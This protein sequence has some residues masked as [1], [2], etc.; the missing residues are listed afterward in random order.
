MKLGK[1]T[2]AFLA[3]A[4]SILSVGALAGTN[5]QTDSFDVY[6]ANVD[7]DNQ[8]DLIFIARERFVLISGE[9][10]VPL[11][12]KDSEDFVLIQQADGTYTYS[13]DFSYSVNSSDKVTLSLLSADFNNDGRND[14]VISQDN[15]LVY[16][17]GGSGSGP[18]SVESVSELAGIPVTPDYSFTQ[19]TAEGGKQGFLVT[20]SVN[21]AT[22]LID[23]YGN[24]LNATRNYRPT[25]I[26]G[27][28]KGRF[29]V[30][31]GGGANY[32]LPVSLPDGPGGYKP[33]I[34]FRYDSQGGNG[35]LGK[36]WSVTG[37]EAIT[38]CSGDKPNLKAP[39]MVKEDTFCINGQT[40]VLVWGVHGENNAQYRTSKDSGTL[41]VARSI[42]SSFGGATYF[43]VYLEDGTTK[44]FG[45]TTNSRILSSETGKVKTW[46]LTTSSQ[47]GGANYEVSYSVNRSAGEFHISSVS[48]GVNKIEY[49]YEERPDRASGWSQGSRFAQTK[50]L[51]SLSVKS[52]NE[53]VR[54]Y[55]VFYGYTDELK[56]S[57]V[58]GIQL[59][60]KTKCLAPAKFQ[61]NGVSASSW[62]LSARKSDFLNNRRDSLIVSDL[63]GDSKAD[64]TIVGKSIDNSGARVVTY[65]GTTNGY[66]GN[67]VDPV[68]N[69]MSA[70]T[71]HVI[72]INGDGHNDLCQFSSSYDIRCTIFF[73]DLVDEDTPTIN[74]RSIYITGMGGGTAHFGDV[75][76]DGLP[77][78]IKADGNNVEV[79]KFSTSSST[80]AASKTARIDEKHDSIATGD[81]NGDGLTDVLYN[82]GK[83]AFSLKYSKGT[84]G[85]GLT[86]PVSISAAN[87]GA[88]TG[89]STAFKQFMLTDMNGDGLSDIVFLPY[90]YDWTIGGNQNE[91]LGSLRVM[92]SNGDGFEDAVLVANECELKYEKSPN[93]LSVFDV[94]GDGRSD[95]V[96][97][98]ARMM[99][100]PGTG[101][102]NYDNLKF[103]VYFTNASG[104]SSS[105]TL[106]DI[107]INTD[108]IRRP[109]E[110]PNPL[111]LSVGDVDGNGT[112]DLV[113]YTTFDDVEAWTFLRNQTTYHNITGIEDSYENSIDI[114]YKPMSD[115]LVYHRID[116]SHEMALQNKKRVYSPGKVLVHKTETDS[117]DRLERNEVYYRYAGAFSDNTHGYLGHS[118]FLTISDRGSH[119]AQLNWEEYGL[120]SATYKRQ[121]FPYVGM[122]EQVHKRNFAGLSASDLYSS[123]HF[124]GELEP[125]AYVAHDGQ[126]TQLYAS[127]NETH[128]EIPEDSLVQLRSGAQ[129]GAGPTSVFNEWKNYSFADGKINKP[130]LYKTSQSL[131]DFNDSNLIRNKTVTTNLYEKVDDCFA[132]Q[133]GT[134]TTSGLYTYVLQVKTTSSN[135]VLNSGCGWPRSFRA[136][137]VETTTTAMNSDWTTELAGLSLDTSKT[138]VTTNVYSADGQIL[139]TGHDNG[140]SNDLYTLFEYENANVVKSTQRPREEADQANWEDRTSILEYHQNTSWVSKVSNPEG[141]VTQTT[142][143]TPYGNPIR[144]IQGATAAQELVF[145]NS[146]D[147]LERISY[148]VSPTGQSTTITRGYCSDGGALVGC[149]DPTKYHTYIKTVVSGAPDQYQFFNKVGLLTKTAI[150]HFDGV[151]YQTV[152]FQYDQYGRLEKES[153]PQLEPLGNESTGTEWTRYYY[154]LNDR[155][156]RKTTPAGG[157][158]TISFETIANV[159]NTQ[160]QV[161]KIGV[162][163]FTG[164]RRIINTKVTNDVSR[165]TI[166]L[167]SSN[168]KLMSVTAPNGSETHFVYDVSGNIVLEKYSKADHSDYLEQ[169]EKK[170]AGFHAIERKFDFHENLVKEIDPSKGE[171]QY[172][173]N[174]FG[175]AIEFITPNVASGNF[176][177]STTLKYDKLGRVTARHSPE[178][179]VCWYFDETS[180]GK[181]LG[182]L[183]E[184][185]QYDSAADCGVASAKPE[186]FTYSS[187]YS[188]NDQGLPSATDEKFVNFKGLTKTYSTTN[189]YDGFGRLSKVFYPGGDLDVRLNYNDEGYLSSLVNDRSPSEYYE[190]LLA[191]NELGETSKLKLGNQIEISRFHE[192][193]RTSKLISK[194]STMENLRLEYAYD[195]A[196]NLTRIEDGVAR[197]KSNE[198]INQ[199][200]RITNLYYQDAAARQLTDVIDKFRASSGYTWVYNSEKYQYDLNGNI[201]TRTGAGTYHYD[202]ENNPHQVSSITGLNLTY[203]YDDNGNVTS[204][205]LR[206]LEYTSFDKPRSITQQGMTTEYKYGPNLERLYR[207]DVKNGVVKE[208][209]NIAGGMLELT[210]EGQKTERRHYVG[211]N[212]T[213]VHKV[214]AN[215][216]IIE[217]KLFNVKDHLGSVV[218]QSNGQGYVL[219]RYRYNP[220]GEQETIY[221][222]VDLGTITL[223][224]EINWSGYV[225]KKGFTGHDH[226]YEMDLIH[227][228]GRVYDHTTGRFLQGDIVV[229]L[230]GFSNAYNRYAYVLNN[231]LSYTDPT[232]YEYECAE[233]GCSLGYA[234]RSEISDKQAA[235]DDQWSEMKKNSIGTNY[236]PYGQIKDPSLYEP[237]VN[238]GR[239]VY[240]ADAA[241][242]TGLPGKI[243]DDPYV[244]QNV[245][246]YLATPEGKAAQVAGTAANFAGLPKAGKTVFK[247]L[248][249]AI[250]NF[251]GGKGKRGKKGKNDVDDTCDVASFVTG[252]NVW[253]EDGLEDIEDIEVGDLVV[254]KSFD[255][256]HVSSKSVSQLFSSYH[257]N[258]VIE[259]IVQNE[260]GEKDVITTTSEH[261]FWV[262]GE[263]WVD[264]AE[265]TL[266]DVLTAQNGESIAI[267][268]IEWLDTGAQTYNFTV[269]DYHTYAVGEFG[270]WVHNCPDEPSRTAA[271]GE[272]F[273]KTTK[274]AT[275]AAKELGYRK[276]NLRT[277]GEA[278]YFNKKDKLYMSRDVGSG[279]GNGAHNGGV[280][281]LAKTAEGLGKKETRMGTYDADLVW[282][283]D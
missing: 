125:I 264:A 223:P 177:S 18:S 75:T 253:I 170:G 42:S 175:E 69:G 282:I 25:T 35:L 76:G 196:G 91:T 236:D 154:D 248:G 238:G 73:S 259:L 163:Y 166:E 243:T 70:G 9:I 233:R 280:W 208:T 149:N 71:S 139:E 181:S 271:K 195:F 126:T 106:K 165:E 44:T 201:L 104:M 185:R 136:Q 130:Y 112:Q 225:D 2:S 186:G 23:R 123:V 34:S 184:V 107:A 46:A 103:D 277:H 242:P 3:F 48:Y 270:V 204:D 101:Y 161:R 17:N 118:V 84:K 216:G 268:S 241:L 150:L 171:S 191:M 121:D 155:M 224:V 93:S 137:K 51:K 39:V 215:Q 119:N 89:M 56:H 43:D 151:N 144:V 81:F 63:S 55:T 72:D 167:Y 267:Q 183:T 257:E 49:N 109:D 74:R 24:P 190:V 234:D 187:G 146:Y 142:S 244:K 272:I 260:N 143:Y 239:I 198:Y 217:E 60:L 194:Y 12:V 229:Q 256:S 117:A 37:S 134:I 54:N 113:A 273:Y 11:I 87:Y 45:A 1:F 65:R 176:E 127:S 135:F 276:T 92:F 15:Q 30:T 58:N 6:E 97:I 36:G 111:S 19:Y 249:Q 8:K 230:S 212:T 95:L 124:E 168:D 152:Y 85:G 172:K 263:G 47:P 274:E 77:D 164:Y 178:G 207:K 99:V 64:F 174:P 203:Q 197:D 140:K 255:T 14:L 41:V 279:D 59:C 169:P 78:L 148:S 145:E 218:L 199:T 86:E 50:R 52:N 240:L 13:N 200:H 252:T 20:Y 159:P 5:L 202:E 245:E 21:G 179:S 10:S 79:Y 100:A 16:L 141:H 231:P 88:P 67:K 82:A 250:G 188:Y 40:L 160:V 83:L 180:A 122:T 147:E 262:V 210:K 246:A 114:E 265:L 158:T 251:F 237:D 173:Y 283:A 232:G 80:N 120:I 38:R 53:L 138:V 32:S 258:D 275:E 108:L 27:N 102:L 214:Q 206:T 90:Y 66:F 132:R 281:K 128:V 222:A 182:M 57:Y 209:W 96:C 254:A 266:L 189:Q 94:N 61:W 26:V 29:T 261:P 162:D 211:S 33:A 68:P 226:I 62:N 105:D 98:K 110:G 7:G 116:T 157:L 247:K 192:Y 133:K 213:I 205:G 219:Q 22:W 31:E 156:V 131:F 28:L 227:M 129:G 228:G 153:F 4:A 235:W 278:V 193:G 221:N 115:P 220:Y 269:A